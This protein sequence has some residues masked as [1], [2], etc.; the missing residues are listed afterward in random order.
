MVVSIYFRTFANRNQGMV[1]EIRI[2]QL[3]VMEIKWNVQLSGEERDKLIPASFDDKDL[4]TDFDY[5]NGGE[6]VETR[7]PS[8]S[9]TYKMLFFDEHGYGWLLL[10]SLYGNSYGLKCISDGNG[11][12]GFGEAWRDMLERVNTEYDEDNPLV[13]ET[14]IDKDS[15]SIS[16]FYYHKDE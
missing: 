7:L 1:P 2:N 15:K 14:M 5:L 6:Y 8:D 13:Q 3:K 4:L 12:V 11:G 16:V 10:Y 9:R